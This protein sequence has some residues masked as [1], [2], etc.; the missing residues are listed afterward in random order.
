MNHALNDRRTS[1][2]YGLR[3]PLPCFLYSHRG[4]AIGMALAQ[5]VSTGG[6]G[7]YSHRPLC[8]GDILSA[9]LINPPPSLRRPLPLEVLHSRTDPDG[10]YL[11]G[12]KFPRSLSDSE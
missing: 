10:G 9:D 8:P 3:P 5:D 2:R 4:Q 7:L 11:T 6:V 12:C 1:P